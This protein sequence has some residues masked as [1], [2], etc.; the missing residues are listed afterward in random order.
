MFVQTAYASHCTTLDLG[1]AWYSHFAASGQGKYA[2][3]I[4]NS[5]DPAF[6]VP[7]FSI[8]QALKMTS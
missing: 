5:S 4:N 8:K 1:T 7:Y 3:V 6:L 2:P